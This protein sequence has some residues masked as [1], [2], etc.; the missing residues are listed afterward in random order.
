M[1]GRD[2][3]ADWSGMADERVLR[4]ELRQ[5]ILGELLALPAIYRAPV[6]LRDI[7][8]LSTEE[9]RAMLRDPLFGT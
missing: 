3:A 5:R 6:V 8:G 9:A 2:E 7:Q 1:T 4:A